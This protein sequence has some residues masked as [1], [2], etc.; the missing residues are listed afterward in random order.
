MIRSILFSLLAAAAISPAAQAKTFGYVELKTMIA[1]KDP[2]TVEDAVAFLP[3]ELRANFTLMHE[4]RSLQ[5]GEPGAPRAIVFN[6]DGSLVMSFTGSD[7]IRGGNRFEIMTF[8]EK[9]ARFDVKTIEFSRVAKATFN[10]AP[11]NCFGCHGRIENDLHPVWDPGLVWR[12]AYGSRDDSFELA[13]SD[14]EIRQEADNYVSFMKNAGTNARYRP[15]DLE[16]KIGEGDRTKIEAHPNLR[17]GLILMRQQAKRV[18]RLIEEAGPTDLKTPLK[19]LLGCEVASTE[20]EFLQQMTAFLGKFLNPIYGDHFTNG[21]LKVESPRLIDALFIGQALGLDI[22]E[23]PLTIEKRSFAIFDGSFAF[24]DQ[25][26][27]ELLARLALRNRTK[28]F[29]AGLRCRTLL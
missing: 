4:S 8:D 13:Q 28:S 18:A 24:A 21:F 6:D 11:Q 9:A 1:E 19:K 25:L 15:L 29:C 26:A 27:S 3:A 5:E 10:E 22:T 12:G 16:Q 14:S 23:W 20:P 17:L 2:R 7:R